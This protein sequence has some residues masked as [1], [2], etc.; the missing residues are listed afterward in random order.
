MNFFFLLRFFSLSEPFTK[1]Q[2]TSST[3]IVILFIR[4]LFLLLG[5]SNVL[6]NSYHMGG[7]TVSETI[8][9]KSVI[10]PNYLVKG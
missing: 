2:H 3:H 10:C 8:L 5:A 9:N 6:Y 7:A 4:Y 1:H